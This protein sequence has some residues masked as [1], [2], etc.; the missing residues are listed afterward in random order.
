MH[1]ASAPF[2]VWQARSLRPTEQEDLHTLLLFSAGK[3]DLD[4][5]SGMAIA[6]RGMQ[7]L[8]ALQAMGGEAEQHVTAA[9]SGVG[10]RTARRGLVEQHAGGLVDPEPTSANSTV[11][12]SRPS[13]MCWLVRMIPSER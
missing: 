1:G 11:T 6:Q 13:T 10:R 3:A 7:V 5:L 12:V 2:V 4:A 9:D 8:H